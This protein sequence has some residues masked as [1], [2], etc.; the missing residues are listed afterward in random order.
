MGFVAQTTQKRGLP[1][2]QGG[3]IQTPLKRG[4]HGS[5]TKPLKKGLAWGLHTNP[6]KGGLHWGLK[7]IIIVT[8]GQSPFQCH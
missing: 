5:C 2:T 7:P 8:D 1:A 6:M 3:G 4:L